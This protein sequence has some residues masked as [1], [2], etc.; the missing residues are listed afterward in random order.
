MRRSFGGAAHKVLCGPGAV[1]GS[2]APPPL[3]RSI[4]TVKSTSLIDR[5]SSLLSI[6]AVLGATL[7]SVSPARAVPYTEAGDAGDRLATAQVVSGP[8]NTAL[9]SIAGTIT[10]SNGISEGDLYQIYISAPTTFSATTTG[11]SP[12]V[13]NFD[14]QLFLFTLGGIG[15]V[16]ND[17]DP[18]SGSPQST[19]P[20]GA[21]TLGAGT[22]DLL[23]T[24]SGRYP[25]STGG[26]IFPN[27]TDGSTDPTGVYGPSGPGGGSPLSTYVGNSNEGGRYSIALTGAQFV[28][29]VV[30]AVP[31]PSTI[32][33]F[34]AGFALLLLAS[35]RRLSSVPN[36]FTSPL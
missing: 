29:A 13:N 2:A 14:T 7:L 30:A 15:I 3:T 9:T 10:L 18:D 11:F 12:G 32:A 25:G 24:G 31:E 34:V 27:F 1:D 16:G 33:I 19:I 20:A 36:A 22:Y 17:D 35:R 6:G 26:L 5:C 8:S 23:I 28:P 4:L 21:F